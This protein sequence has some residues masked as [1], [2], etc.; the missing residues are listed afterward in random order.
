[1]I[2]LP[3]AYALKIGHSGAS[4][5]MCAYAS[6]LALVGVL[7]V[8]TSVINQPAPAVAVEFIKIIEK[9]IAEQ[10]QNHHG[11][12]IENFD[13][14]VFRNQQNIGEARKQLLDR[15]QGEA[16][17]IQSTCQFGDQ[18]KEKL[19]LAGRGDIQAFTRLYAE[20]R[21]KFSEELDNNGQ[22]AMQNIWQEIRPL[23]NKYHS[24]IFGAGSLFEKVLDHLLDEQQSAR[25]D[26]LRREQRAFQFKSAVMQLVSQIDQAAPI[27]RENRE[28]LLALI[29]RYALPPKS[30]AGHNHSHLLIYYMLGQM[31]EIPED[32]LRPLFGKPAWKA[33]QQQMQQ[34][35]A[36]KDHLAMQGLVPEKD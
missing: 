17:S 22:Q 19:L 10:N 5:Q 18:Q 27:R 28:K 12:R 24:Q 21:A 33:I 9:Q 35:K 30:M 11:F 13:Q 6:L 34:G 8:P 20:L 32:E 23:Q 7:I 29:D 31:V 3:P 1:M 36:L 15:L 14:W 25:I 26:Q 16:E 4:R 2:M